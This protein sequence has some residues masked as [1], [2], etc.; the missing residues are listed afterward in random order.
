MDWH[1]QTVEATLHTL[2][3]TSDGL[4]QDEAKARLAK[5]GLNELQERKHFSRFKLF[6]S[7]LANPL[8]AILS[9]AAL[10][11]FILGSLLDGSVILVTIAVMVL[12]AF[13][14]EAKAEKAMQALKQLSPP[15]AKVKRKGK[16]ILTAAKNITPGDILLLEAGDLIPAD[17][18]LIS[19]SHFQTS[20]ATLTGES[21]PIEKTEDKLAQT[22]PL[23]ERRNMVY[24]GTT[25]A[26]GKGL[27][28]VTATG[29][30]TE[31]GAIAE[32]IQTAKKDLSPLQ[33][34]IRTLGH[35]MLAIVSIIVVL[36]AGIGWFFGLGWI[37]L[38]L[39]CI[40]LAVAAIPE[41]LPATVTIVLASGVHLLSKKK[42]I[43]RKL[44]A[45]ETLG[46]TNVI[47]TDKTGTLTV[48]QM[49]VTAICGLYKKSGQLNQTTATPCGSFEG[50]S[51][52]DL[53]NILTIGALCNEATLSHQEG[54]SSYVG[55]PTDI[56]L[57]DALTHFDLAHQP[58]K[59]AFPRSKEIPFSSE[60]QYMATLHKGE[61]ESLAFIKGSPEK[62][63]ARCTHGWHK[64]ALHPLGEKERAWIE[65]KLYHMAAQGLR[66][67]ALAFTPCSSHAFCEKKLEQGL[68]FA[69][70]V[71]MID[72]PRREV[73]QA[74]AACHRAG[75][76]VKMVTGDNRITAQA[77]AKQ[78]GIKEDKVLT[79]NELATLT[80]HELATTLNTT[81]VFARIEPAHKLH[82]VETLKKR[83]LVV[84]MTGDGV[85]DAPALEAA[86]IGV[87]MGINGTDVAKEA[88]D[89]ILTDDNFATIIDCIEE[90]RTIFNRL[91]HSTAFLLTTC[92]GEV[93][94]ILL[95]FLTHHLSPLEPLQILWINLITG[96]IIAIP[97]GMEPKIGDELTYPPRD[98]R[99]GLIFPGMVLRMVFLALM[100]SLG[101][102]A[103]FSF[104]LDR[105]ELETARSMTFC[106][107]VFFELLM[108]LQ[109][110]SDEISIQRLGWFKNRLL[111]LNS[112]LA[113][114]LLSAIM[115]IP[116]LQKGFHTKGLSLLDWLICLLP[117]AAVFLIE[118]VR[119]QVAPKLF[120]YGKWS[121]L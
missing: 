101:A 98:S 115:Y 45:V 69:G 58:L 14:Q 114:I 37:D 10:L 44:I 32:Q 76:K 11:K 7:Q 81:D 65:D 95:T 102:F 96:S 4:T 17:A 54:S 39:L 74:I 46:S 15:Q 120:S 103:I 30:Q 89:M 25:V 71:G 22:T 57:I 31:I 119:K 64:G 53:Q 67:L 8:V 112:A 116:W 82:I 12:I 73:P 1:A 55:D 83:H 97:L 117:G 70:L 106:S 56:A 91:R 18:R 66:V 88:S 3:A 48:N 86:D 29:M 110:R 42:G 34:S 6:F 63:V 51:D 87:A 26:Y 100:L 5:H 24:A 75:I 118:M 108:A 90:G 77:I 60:K 107:I 50:P 36:F 38:F 43:M 35:W 121:R 113:L 33:K 62:L 72:P 21:W 105:K 47:C 109:L 2:E 80:E 28:A 40:A 13:F 27:A 79:G 104:A 9:T 68:I 78:V 41:G 20:E 85:N 23:A 92:L 19:V 16:T 94:T 111:A 61:H 49:T 52:P 99:V 59:S 84:A 93:A